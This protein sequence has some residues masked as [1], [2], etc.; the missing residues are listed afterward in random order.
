MKSTLLMSVTCAL[1]LVMPGLAPAQIYGPEVF[2]YY[3]NLGDNY[4][5]EMEAIERRQ[6]RQD[7]ILQRELDRYTPDPQVDFWRR[8]NEMRERAI[9]SCNFL[10]RNPAARSA[11]LEAIR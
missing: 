10:D 11:C 1:A 3:D 7:Q 6:R 8:E 9:E 5:R 2:D 4:R